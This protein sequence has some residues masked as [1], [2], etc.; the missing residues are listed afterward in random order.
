MSSVALPMSDA[1]RHRI[2]AWLVLAAIA[3]WLAGLAWSRPL[4]LPDEGRYAGVAWEM[5]R[6]HS[7]FV[8][9]MDGMPYFHKPPLYYWL[10]QLSFAVFGLSEWAA[11][12]PSL[13]IA[14]ASI[15]GVYGFARRYRGER[16]ASAP[17]WCSPACPFSMAGRSSPTWICRSPA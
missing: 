14:W 8:P 5:L 2:P 3:L 6:S 12:L 17:C 15:A 7:Y 13:L 4:T 16:F 1:A 10:A 9:L 11:R